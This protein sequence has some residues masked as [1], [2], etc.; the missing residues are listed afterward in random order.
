MDKN[1][2]GSEYIR[3]DM[4]NVML[5]K[6]KI[7]LMARAAI[8]DKEY[9]EED[10]KI[11]GYYQKDYVSLNVWITLIWVTAG[12]FLT[13][14]LL[15]ISNSESIVEGIT[16]VRLLLLAAIVLAAYLSLMIIYGIGVSTFYRKRHAQAKQRVKKYMRDLSRL[17]KMNLIKEKN[18]S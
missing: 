7:R 6:R 14:A 11:T 17:E 4:R 1:K 8:Y 9:G 13:A 2:T 10:L 15:F 3:K 16:I 5:D 18:R 12:F